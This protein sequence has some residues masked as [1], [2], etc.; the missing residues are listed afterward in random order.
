[1][2]KKTLFFLLKFLLIVKLE[3]ALVE[4]FMTLFNLQIN[5]EFQ[6]KA[7]KINMELIQA[8]IH[9]QTFK[10]VQLVQGMLDKAHV[11]LLKLQ[12]DGDLQVLEHFLVH[13][14]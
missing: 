10:I 11:Q 12:K 13:Q 1:M 3:L 6:N 8:K 7:V 4:M 2:V 9:V 5:L 14:K